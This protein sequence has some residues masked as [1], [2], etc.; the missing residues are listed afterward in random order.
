[1]GQTILIGR[2][3]LGRKSAGSTQTRTSS[4]TVAKHQ[5]KFAMSTEPRDKS[6]PLPRTHQIQPVWYTTAPVEPADASPRPSPFWRKDAATVSDAIPTTTAWE[7]VCFSVAGILFLRMT[8]SLCWDMALLCTNR[9]VTHSAFQKGM[10]WKWVSK[11]SCQ[12]ERNK[13]KALAL[14]RQ[15]YQIII[16]TLTQLIS[17]MIPCV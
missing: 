6:R 9:F 7:S 14:M 12:V 1:M 13:S 11:C 16:E 8:W 17:I 3:Y 15:T 10:A 2:G 5:H 4:G